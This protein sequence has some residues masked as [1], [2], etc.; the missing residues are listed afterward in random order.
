MGDLLIQIVLRS[1]L[2]FKNCFRMYLSYANWLF[3]NF[4]D[5][6]L[7]SKSSYREN[8]KIFV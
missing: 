3:P 2:L 5:R 7:V 4:Q 8:A 6:M 1:T